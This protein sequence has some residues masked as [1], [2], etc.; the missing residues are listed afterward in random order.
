MLAAASK[1]IV[2]GFN[3]QAEAAAR[4]FSRGGRRLD[5]TVRY[6]L[7]VNRGSGKSSK[8]YAGARGK[9]TVIGHADV[10][11][12]FK[13]SKLGYIA[14]CRVSDGELRRNAFVRV[15]RSGTEIHSGTV[16]SLKHLQEDVREVRQGFE[17]GI[18]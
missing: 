18:G 4:R 10:R 13:I 7:P 12:V 17:C 16:S 2:I 6:Y 11:A 8:G 15:L 1:A 5:Q 9:Q 14:G 3:V